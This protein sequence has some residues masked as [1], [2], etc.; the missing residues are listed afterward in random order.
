MDAKER[1]LNDVA[2]VLFV[3]NK[4]ERDGE[5][6]TLMALDELPEGNFIPF[7]CAPNELKVDLRLSLADGLQGASPCCRSLP[8]A[9][10]RDVEV[11]RG[12]P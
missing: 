12:R 10:T 8:I 2:S 9:D 1:V 6:P 4:A 5:R 7:L 3:T 11:R